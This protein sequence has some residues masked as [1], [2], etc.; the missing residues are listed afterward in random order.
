[1]SVLAFVNVTF[2]PSPPSPPSMFP[3]PTE[4]Q[5]AALWGIVALVLMFAML[6]RAFRP[7]R[8]GC[9]EMCGYSRTGIGEHVI[10]PE[11]GQSP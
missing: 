3:D 5:Q 2:V 11:C 9:C 6:M 8:R 1:M 7:I 4:P 10:C